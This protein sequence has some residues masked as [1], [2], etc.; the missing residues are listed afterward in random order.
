L[1]GKRELL[2]WCRDSQGR[3]C[4]RAEGIFDYLKLFGRCRIKLGSIGYKCHG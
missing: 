1:A 2:G 3:G 4:T